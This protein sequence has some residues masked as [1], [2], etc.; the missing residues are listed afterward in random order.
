MCHPSPLIITLTPEEVSVPE[1]SI[2]ADFQEDARA[3]RELGA[4][5]TS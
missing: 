5:P 2:K 3:R 4:A 1:L